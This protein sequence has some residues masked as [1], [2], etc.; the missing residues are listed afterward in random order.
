MASKTELRREVQKEVE[1]QNDKGFR[2]RENEYS[3]EINEHA[4]G[5]AIDITKGGEAM[6]KV[7][8]QFVA[9]AQRAGYVASGFKYDCGI[10]E[11]YT[12]VFLHA[13]DEYDPYQYVEEEPPEDDELDEDI[14]REAA[15]LVEEMGDDDDG[16]E[17]VIEVENL[18]VEVDPLSATDLYPHHGVG[19]MGPNTIGE[20]DIDANEIVREL[21]GVETAADAVE[22]IQSRTR[23][24]VAHVSSN[25]R[26]PED[27]SP[28][29][30]LSV[31]NKHIPDGW[32]RWD[33]D[34]AYLVK[35]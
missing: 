19:P 10:D 33:E 5:P 31:D 26:A 22:H 13:E 8:G 6:E 32:E 2:G 35:K 34:R 17:V 20:A 24:G 23:E 27:E 9:A 7:I 30:L 1:R 15:K 18:T 29:V 4:G 12:R 3:A 16:P 14:E 11:S 25:H 28:Y 21:E